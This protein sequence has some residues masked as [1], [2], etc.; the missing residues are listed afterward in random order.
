MMP[1]SAYC[2][3]GCTCPAGPSTS[4]P[5]S[6]AVNSVLGVGPRSHTALLQLPLQ[7][8]SA[9]GSCQSSYGLERLRNRTLSAGAL[10]SGAGACSSAEPSTSGRQIQK[11]R[12]SGAFAA[13]GGH[14]GRAPQMQML[15][16]GG[17]DNNNVAAHCAFMPMGA[18]IANQRSGV[19]CASFSLP[20]PCLSGD[21]KSG[22]IRVN[23]T[24]QRTKIGMSDAKRQ[25]TVRCNSIAFGAPGPSNNAPQFPLASLCMR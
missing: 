1:V 16:H 4:S 20:G 22:T 15:R 14:V 2:N 18:G 17:M 5:S 8:R 10:V 25:R 6:T 7:C 19:A 23:A 21:A 9:S 13:A 3:R 24:L 11:G 12:H